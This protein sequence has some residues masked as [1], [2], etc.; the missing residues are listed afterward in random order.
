VGGAPTFD[1]LRSPPPCPSPTRGEGTLWRPPRIVSTAVLSRAVRWAFLATAVLVCLAVAAVAW[2]WV[3][4]EPLSLARA[5]ALSVTVLDRNDKLLRAYAAPDGRW[6][7]P[8]EVKEVDPRYLAM[9]LAFEDKRFRAHSGVD[10]WAMLRAGWQ[11]IRYQRIVSGGSTITMQLVRLLLGQ[12]ER[13]LWGKIRQALL[14]LQLE[15][16]YS[17]DEIL[18][19]YLR[20]APFGGN[21][22]GVRAAS[23]AYFGKEPRRLS[24][25]EAALLV[26]I[27]QSPEARR[28]DRSPEATGRARN[29]VLIRVLAAGAVSGDDVARAL[30]EPMPPVS[31]ARREFPM[32]APHLADAEVAKHPGRVIVHRL[33]LDRPAQGA[34]EA[35]VRDYVAALEGRLSAALVVVD[36]RTGEI[37]AYVGSPGLLDVERAGAIDMAL[38]L[39]SPGSTLKPI[40]YGLAFELGLAHPDTLIE[41]APQRFGLYVPKN[42]DTEW[43]GSVTIR[44]A[45]IHS[46]NIPAVKVLEAVGAGRLYSRLQQTGVDPVLPKGAEPSLAMALG[47]VGLRLVDLAQLYAAIARGGEPVPLKHTRDG[48][49][50]RGPTAGQRLMSEIA[51]WYV[52][53]ILCRALPPAN[54]KAGEVCYKTGTS[55]GFRDA[56]S[57]GFDG[58]HVIAVWVGRADGAAVSGLTGRTTA[59]PLLF[60]AFARLS[61]KRAPLPPPPPGVI[62][63]KTSELPPPLKRFREGAAEDGASDRSVVEPAPRIAF[64]P[65]RAEIE[66]EEG[67]DSTVAVKAE[68]GVLPLTWLLDGAPLA[69]DP[70]SREAELPAGRRGFFR[71]SVIDAK[72]RADRVT[73]R[74]R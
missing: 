64:P 69:S 59:A 34:L 33:T 37:V 68:G 44:A 39:R 66:V 47:G 27:P 41:D 65:D 25:A 32:L 3:T 56:W 4:L 53:D 21:L 63:A 60:D 58:R 70:M 24:A 52:R 7:L 2:V 16:H 54:A 72:G 29:R 46:L 51:A 20:L 62:R 36:H 49:A 61:L 38:A 10:V 19:L 14:A 71:L 11:L 13:S 40:I 45:L 26:A 28:P 74:V 48:P 22:E 6:R 12:H 73:I 55:Y 43:H 15:R 17:K 1:L 31:L 57:V 30:A 35:L 5:E 18:A 42:F 23:L 8:V 67:E 50:P 9:L